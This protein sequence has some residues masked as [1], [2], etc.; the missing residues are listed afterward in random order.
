MAAH[1]EYSAVDPMPASLSR[2]WITGIL[3]GTLGFHGCVFADDLSMAGAAAFGDVVERTRLALAA[4][5]DVLPICNDRNAVRTVLGTL[6]AEAV[7]PAAQVR[8]VRM[9]ARGEAAANLRGTAAWQDAA[10]VVAEL[11][12]APPLILTEGQS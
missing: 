3:R 11:A 6:D 12:A 8:L 10:A 2:R 7:T 5:C 4:G 9:R 1:V